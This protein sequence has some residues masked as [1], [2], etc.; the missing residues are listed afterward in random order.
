MVKQFWQGIQTDL[1][2]RRIHAKIAQNNSEHGINLMLKCRSAHVH[3]TSHLARFLAKTCNKLKRAAIRKCATGRTAPVADIGVKCSGL[4]PHPCISDDGLVLAPNHTTMRPAYALRSMAAQHTTTQQIHKQTNKSYLAAGQYPIVLAPKT[5]SSSLFAMEKEKTTTAPALHSQGMPDGPPEDPPTG[6]QAAPPQR[7]TP[8]PTA[9]ASLGHCQRSHALKILSTA[10]LSHKAQNRR[11]NALR[12]WIHYTKTKINTAKIAARTVH[13]FSA[14]ALRKWQCLRVS[15]D[16]HRTTKNAAS[17]LKARLNTQAKTSH[18]N[19]W[20]Q[21]AQDSSAARLPQVQLFLRGDAAG[22]LIITVP[23]PVTRNQLHKII[24][25]E[26]L[27]PPQGQTLGSMYQYAD[28]TNADLFYMKDNCTIDIYSL[29]NGGSGG[30]RSTRQAKPPP[31]QPTT[32]FI[33]VNGPDRHQ[34]TVTVLPSDKIRRVKELIQPQVDLHPSSQTLYLA[35]KQLDDNLI[36]ENSGIIEGTPCSSC[37]SSPPPSAKN[38][39]NLVIQSNSFRDTPPTA[40]A[41]Y[42]SAAQTPPAAHKDPAKT[43]LGPPPMPPLSAQYP[44]E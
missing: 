11:R 40:G 35:G 6:T 34:N 5:P 20:W 37:A 9:V 36:L 13:T 43:T 12:N 38:T 31:R 17:A 8:R 4:S 26:T 30:S 14:E 2:A 28:A 22:S 29:L 21:H 27:V 41:G 1:K 39:T 10:V 42:G 7:A 24:A 18:F 44:L 19:K 25:K 32:L 33:Y 15:N 23:V 16:K 3:T